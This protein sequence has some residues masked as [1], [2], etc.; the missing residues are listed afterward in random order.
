MVKTRLAL[1]T[2]VL[3]M[4][5][6]SPHLWARAD[7]KTAFDKAYDFSSIETWGWS[8]G[9]GQIKMARTQSD[10]PEF[11]RALIEP[12]ILDGVEKELDKKLRK[13]TT[14]PDV[15]FRYYMLL[16]T[17]Q[18]SQTVGQF[19]PGTVNWGL[20]L[21]PPATQSLK[22]LNAGT[23]VLDVAAKDTVIWRG[24]AQ[25]EVKPD[26]TQEKR[27]SVLREAIRDML[28]NFPPKKK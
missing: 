1:L 23:L 14:A 2:A 11:M 7:V 5:S 6:L 28:K 12:I 3:A 10:D 22:I 13:V 16:T 8:N 20:P 26:S 18:T 19:I 4:L 25:A 15:T 9:W 21:F 24:A 17:S 27:E